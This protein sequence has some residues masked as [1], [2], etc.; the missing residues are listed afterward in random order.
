MSK[1]GIMDIVAL[2]KAGYKASEVKELMQIEVPEQKTEEAPA[3]SENT[4][5]ATEEKAKEQKIQEQV[6]E[7]DST[8]TSVP[9]ESAIDYK[10]KFEEAESKLQKLQEQNTRKNMQPEQTSDPLSGIDDFLK[11]IM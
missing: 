2:A 4:N 8:S 11:S 6:P 7:N 1:L 9:S 10:K 3:G 5:P